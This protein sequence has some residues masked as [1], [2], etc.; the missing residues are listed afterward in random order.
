MIKLKATAGTYAANATIPLVEIFNTNREFELNNGVIIKSPGLVELVGNININPTTAGAITISVLVD[1][2]V[3]ST[4]K[5]V[6]AGNSDVVSIS[7]YDLYR[8]IP[9]FE[10]TYAT[11]TIKTSVAS[12]V[13][14]GGII[15]L[16]YIR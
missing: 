11:I 15:S 12:T 14:D 7:L 9:N 5:A 2:D 6:T 8:V 4:S 3:V 16:K 10:N 13:S 1:D